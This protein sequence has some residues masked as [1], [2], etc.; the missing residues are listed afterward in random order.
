MSGVFEAVYEDGVLKPLKRL[1][2]REGQRVKVR[3][4]EEDPIRIAREIRSHLRERLQKRDLVMELGR[5]RER[6]G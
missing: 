2:L 3:I 5:E 1:N 6:F 4:I